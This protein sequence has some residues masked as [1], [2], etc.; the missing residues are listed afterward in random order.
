MRRGP[1]VSLSLKQR[2]GQLATSTSVPSSPLSP[3]ASVSG[4]R[5][6]YFPT[7]GPKRGSV[8]IDDGLPR[9]EERMHGV[10]SKMIFQAGVDFEVV[11]CASALPDPREV[12]YD[13][14]LTRILAYLDLYVESDYTVVFF[15]AGN[16]HTPGWN[17]IWRAYRS[18]SRK[19]RKN[20]KKLFIVHTN[21]FSKSAHFFRKIQYMNTLSALAQYVP[22]NLRYEKQITLPVA[23]RSNLF[24]V[25]LEDLMG[26][27][28]EKGDIPRVV[29][30]CAQYLRQT[31]M[32][33][34]GLFRRSPNTVMLQQAK[35]AYDRGH[36]VSLESFGDAHLAAVLLKKF[37][38]DLPEPIVP[39]DCYPIIRKCPPASDNPADVTTVN[40]IRDQILPSLHS[41]AAVVLLSYVLHLMHNVTLRSAHNRMDAHNLALVLAPNL[42]AG[43]NPAR[44]VQMCLMSGSANPLPFPG[45][46]RSSSA[47]GSMSLSA[48]LKICI[49]RYFEIF[50]EH[51]DRGEAL[52]PTAANSMEPP[53]APFVVSDDTSS[54]NASPL[55]MQTSPT[56]RGPASPTRATASV[57]TPPSAFG[58]SRYRVM[59]TPPSAM[60][61]SAFASNG[62]SGSLADSDLP[63]TRSLYGGSDNVSPSASGTM[64][65]KTRSLLS[66]EKT[67]T[68]NGGR[69]SISLSRGVGT[70]RKSTGAAVE[71]ISV[72]ASGF[73]TPPGGAPA[74]VAT[75]STPL[76]PVANTELSSGD[77][78]R[79][80]EG[81]SRE[82]SEVSE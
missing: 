13:Q 7:W 11:I 43:T 19:Y 80:R 77:S 35:Q 66:I 24:G 27:D 12:S 49:E 3:P 45:L 8:D 38:K 42:V 58:K 48:V 1:N 78:A 56:Q 46:Q 21:W 5:K 55:I 76:P 63:G 44:D 25:P 22:E 40:Y 60:Q 79:E 32:I 61:T 26:T 41:H 47:E 71:A 34:E 36:P 28:G 54:D 62:S 10:V 67:L 20:L 17:W 57:S 37:L 30:D 52:A 15:A 2:L 53:S 51:R 39:E 16:K 75:P 14:L 74:P 68:A 18:L 23:H 70:L 59:S 72:T 50:D 33:E 82:L 31:G 81:K 9:D 29:K 73:F 65:S 6:S 4:T 64:R 69:G